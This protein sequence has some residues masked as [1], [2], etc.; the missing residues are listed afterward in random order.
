MKSAVFKIRSK[1]HTKWRLFFTREEQQVK[2]ENRLVFFFFLPPEI[3]INVNSE[4]ARCQTNSNLWLTIKFPMTKVGR[5]NYAFSV[6]DI[7]KSENRESMGKHRGH[8]TTSDRYECIKMKKV[9]NFL[10]TIAQLF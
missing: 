8:L 10:S 5:R 3:Y 6:S 7:L 1:L 4:R 2:T 9:F